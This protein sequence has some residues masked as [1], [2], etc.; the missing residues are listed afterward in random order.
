MK[1]DIMHVKLVLGYVQLYLLSK[2]AILECPSTI[3]FYFWT[4]YMD[5]S[6]NLLS[7]VI[8]PCT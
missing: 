2:G 8:F 4:K 6:K 3:K 1:F 5:C 7:L